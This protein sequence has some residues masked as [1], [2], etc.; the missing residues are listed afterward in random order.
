MN[1]LTPFD[2]VERFSES[3]DLAI[4]GTASAAGRSGSMWGR[5]DEGK[6]LVA[7]VSAGG[8]I[9]LRAEFG[10]GTDILV[11]GG[12]PQ[13]WVV[14]PRRED[15]P[16]PIV[17]AILPLDPTEGVQEREEFASKVD[18]LFT[19]SPCL[20]NVRNSFHSDGLSNRVAAIQL[21]PKLLV[22]KSVFITGFSLG[23]TSP[24]DDAPSWRR[25]LSFGLRRSENVFSIPEAALF[26]RVINKIGVPVSITADVVDIFARTG[27]K[28]GK[29]LEVIK[30]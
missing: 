13:S 15:A 30:R 10:N 26:C 1:L 27:T 16:S 2:L 11:T 22:P 5:I 19:Y 17:L 28:L 8:P 20:V 29:R 4:V 24:S 14:P 9:P 21:L 25:W 6:A 3:R 23:D 7:Q 18:V 12:D